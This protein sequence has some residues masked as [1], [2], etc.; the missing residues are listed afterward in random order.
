MRCDLELAQNWRNF[1]AVWTGGEAVA[2]LVRH[3]ANSRSGGPGNWRHRIGAAFQGTH[4]FAPRSRLIGAELA[5]IGA[6]GNN[7]LGT[8]CAAV[9]RGNAGQR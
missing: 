9:A 6:H 8:A 4:Q 1:G 7:A 2:A 5:Q 3:C